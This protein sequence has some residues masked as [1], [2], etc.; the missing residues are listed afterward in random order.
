[1]VLFIENTVVAYFWMFDLRLNLLQVVDSVNVDI[2]SNQLSVCIS[3]SLV[4]L[5]WVRSLTR[6]IG[7]DVPIPMQN[8]AW[9]IQ[10][11]WNDLH[12]AGAKILLFPFLSPPSALLLF[13][14]CPP[15]PLPFPVS[16]PLPSHLQPFPKI[17]LWGARERCKREGAILGD[18]WVLERDF[19]EY[20]DGACCFRGW[21]S[22][23]AG[24]RE[25]GRAMMRI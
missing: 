14:P 22:A 9:T 11:R 2:N 1:M 25:R 18:S 17:Q 6:S 15:R 10:W 8:R 7:P 24:F 16:L 3:M 21:R 20:E 19:R 5:L 13:L 23:K 12:I 4:A